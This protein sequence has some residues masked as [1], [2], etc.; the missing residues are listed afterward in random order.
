M[1]INENL[2]PQS[3]NHPGS[4]PERHETVSL[5][6]PC[7][8]IGILEI[9]GIAQCT[10]KHFLMH[11]DVAANVLCDFYQSIACK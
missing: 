4:M 5:Q 8:P 11:V 6:H 10:A 2:Q 1:H 3:I 7:S 9:L